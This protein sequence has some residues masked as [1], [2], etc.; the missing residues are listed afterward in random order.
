MIS[1]LDE[2][3]K[4]LLIKNGNFNHGE[5]DIRF[6]APDREWSASLSKPTID[7]YL[8]DIRENHELRGTE[9]IIEKNSNN[10]VT[11]RKNAKRID[12]SYLVTIW[13]NNIEDQHS[14]LWRVLFTLIQHPTI[15]SDLLQGQLANQAYPVITR[16]GQPDGLFNNPADF[17]AALDNEI[18]PS[19]NYVV[20]LPMDLDMAVTSA[21]TRTRTLAV[22][23]P[24]TEPE[25]LISI[26]G[27]VFV[28]GH[29][30]KV[31]PSATVVATEA[32]MTSMTDDQGRYSFSRIPSGKQTFQVV[33]PGQKP[34]LFTITVPDKAYD[35][36][37]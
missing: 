33:V 26:S 35:I 20:T 16:A 13:S 30:E 4:Q 5:V 1:E 31:V 12:L 32:N 18:K 22:K 24:E 23:R 9:W 2:T 11:K 17:W 10:T 28:K 8:Y 25:M 6:E 29:P 7:L 36:E 27:T 21:I 15:P 37:I 14:L 34:K 19:F 3:I